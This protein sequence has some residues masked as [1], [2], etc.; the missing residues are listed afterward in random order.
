MSSDH[1][2]DVFADHTKNSENK[3]IHKISYDV[4]ILGSCNTFDVPKKLSISIVYDLILMNCII[5]FCV[6]SLSIIIKYESAVQ[7]AN[8][9]KHFWHL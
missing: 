6:K 8:N 4:Y 2:F 9:L 5:D 7:T 3:I 1:E